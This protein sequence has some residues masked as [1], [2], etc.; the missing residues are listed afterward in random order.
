MLELNQRYLHLHSSH[1]ALVC[2]LNFSSK[3]GEILIFKCGALAFLISNIVGDKSR[4]NNGFH[5]ENS[6]R[7]LSLL[8]HIIHAVITGFLISFSISHF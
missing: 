2:V 8:S 6:G 5:G 4:S 3:A 1:S 7:G